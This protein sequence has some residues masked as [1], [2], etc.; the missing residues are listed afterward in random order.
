M[1][2]INTGQ[3]HLRFH[4]VDLGALVAEA[5]EDARDEAEHAGCT[6]GLQGNASLVAR[7]DPTRIRQVIDNLL[8]NAV[9]FG[10]GKPV[11]VK[12][13]AWGGLAR[14]TVTDHGIG[15]DPRDRSRIFERFER[16]VS[17][18]HYGGFGLGL[19]I[20]RQVVEAHRGDITVTPTPGGGSTF[21]LELPLEAT[22]ELEAGA[23]YES[24]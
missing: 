2:R 4:D 17:S 13:E 1:S 19:W 18:R 22:A 14:V 9:K 12:L 11:E 5:V 7:C 6:L 10:R 15:I 23:G 16:A 20:A 8:S 24:P 3:L 21:T